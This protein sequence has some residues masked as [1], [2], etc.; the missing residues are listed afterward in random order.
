MKNTFLTLIIFSVLLGSCAQSEYNLHDS[1]EQANQEEA[2]VFM[3]TEQEFISVEMKEPFNPD[4]HAQFS[5]A[6]LLQLMAQ[7]MDDITPV[8]PD[9]PPIMDSEDIPIWTFNHLI[10]TIFTNGQ[11]VYSST[12][13]IIDNTEQNPILDVVNATV[14][15]N[16]IPG[17]VE[18]SGGILYVYN[19]E[20]DLIC[21][22][23]HSQ[24]NLR[25]YADSLSRYWRLY[26]EYIQTES[27]AGPTNCSTADHPLGQ[28]GYSQVGILASGDLV[29][30]RKSEESGITSKIVC[31]PDYRKIRQEFT[32]HGEQLVSCISTIYA[33]DHQEFRT[34]LPNTSLDAPI[35]V[36]SQNLILESGIPK[37]HTK[38]DGYSKNI[39]KVHNYINTE[40]Y[41]K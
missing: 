20:N 38:I 27:N 36:I 21:R 3:T 37:I 10:D 13:Q 17:K 12:F 4:K 31:S 40:S 33:I 5:S 25:F 26:Q 24:P 7:R 18:Y 9:S 29:L 28:S 23:E 11:M 35:K 15:K 30:E 16:R 8:D 39:T 1:K 41:E 2:V 32:L 14:D 6:A 22:R 19:Q 34:F